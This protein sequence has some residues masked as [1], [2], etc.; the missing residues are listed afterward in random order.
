MNNYKVTLFTP[1]YNRANTLPRLFEC[2]KNQTYNNIE[3]I[4]IDDGSSDNTKEVVEGFL[5]ETLDFPL[6][7]KYQTNHGKHIATN[8]AVEMAT[9][10]FFVTIDSDDAFK[11]NAIEMFL[12]EWDKIPDNEKKNYKGISCRT[13][14]LNEKMN[15][16]PLPK[17][18]LDCT[19]L[20]LRMIHKV[21]GEL[22]GMTRMDV[23]REFPYPQ[24]EGLHFYPENIHWDTV[25]RKYKTRFVDI[26]LR[27]YINDTGNALTNKTTTT[28]KE[29]Y[30]MRVHFINDCWDYFK[31]DR[32][33]FIKQTVGLTRDGLYSKKTLGEIL[34]TPNTFSKKLLT[35][36]AMPLGCVLYYKDKR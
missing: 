7:Y 3:W 26:P 15:G 11:P 33:Y 25:G 35:L 16:E 30:F 29:T 12:Q 4:I 24:I 18:P 9:G 10:D 5:T 1:A 14:D 23:I 20:D 36:L 32:K 31:Y 28:S 22:W 8:V 13:C 27:Y 21:E 17:S 6:I 34:K 2:V 19:D